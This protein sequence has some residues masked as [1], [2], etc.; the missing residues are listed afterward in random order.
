[1]VQSCL[2]NVKPLFSPYHTLLKE[3]EALE[4]NILEGRRVLSFT[5]ILGELQY[6]YIT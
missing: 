4:R 1:M 2:V 5:F 3:R 6:H